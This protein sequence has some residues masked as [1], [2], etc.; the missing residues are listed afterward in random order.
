VAPV[1]GRT[2]IRTVVALTEVTS[3]SAGW[4][5]MMIGTS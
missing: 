4:P 3:I 5:A 1:S 2:V